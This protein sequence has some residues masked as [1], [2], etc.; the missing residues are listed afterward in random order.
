MISNRLYY[1]LTL[2]ATVFILS[3]C[4]DSDDD[5][6]V[7]YDYSS[8]AQLTSLKL[9]S[10][11][12]TLKVLPSV[13]FSINQVASAPVIFNRDSLPYLFDVKNV[14]MNVSTN[15]ASGIKLRLINPDSTYIWDT[16]DSVEINRLR[17]I[18]VYAADGITSKMYTFNLNVHQQ[19]PDTIFWQNVTS[20]YIDSPT[21]QV[22]IANANSFYT[23]YNGS[24]NIA[25]STSS[26]DDGETWTKQT[27]TGLPQ[28]VV[29]KSIQNNTF[30]E[31]EV[32]CALDSDSKV[33]LSE[34]GMDWTEQ[35]TDL[36]VR[37]IFGKMPSYS[38]DSVLLVV[39]DEGD[40]KF[41]KT[42]DF[43]TIHV[44]NKLPEGFPVDNFTSTTIKDSLIY[45]AK[46]LITTGGEDINGV[47]N[48]KVWLL[49]ENEGE[50]T[51][52]SIASKFNVAG[53]SLFN[54][55]DKIYL[56]TPEDDDN[57]F[58]TSSNYGMFWKRANSKQSLPSEFIVRE[59]QSVNVDNKNNIWI[60]GGVS[61][62][63]AQLVE[64]WKGRINKLFV[65]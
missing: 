52:T 5:N 46:Y 3:S 25:L 6:T 16:S 13:E 63:Q 43:S 10:N 61:A 50:I 53:S 14:S 41:A 40:Y 44:L 62:N 24:A 51:H 64:V 8:D 49:Q 65:R 31:R 4:L 2:L 29:F 59:N 60:F 23:Y 54:Y 28:N 32:W 37:S 30:E 47:S 35:S 9:Q 21:D 15:G 1:C 34:D 18:E 38:T 42:I 11:E 22:T 57:V 45:T 55:D 17:H 36:H 12:D 26:I 27:V 33:Y 7:D 56:M 39:E 19:D 58:Y 20:N 48:N